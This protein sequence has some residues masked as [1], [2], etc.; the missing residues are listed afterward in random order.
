MIHLQYLEFENGSV[1]FSKEEFEKLLAEHK[2]NLYALWMARAKICKL[3]RLTTLH[4]Q[5]EWTDGALNAFENAERKCL[6][7]A[8]E[9]E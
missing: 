7:K 5:W 3:E 1:Q 4:R 9:F 2:R 8:K 6:E